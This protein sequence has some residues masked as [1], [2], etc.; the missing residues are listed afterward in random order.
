MFIFGFLSR[1]ALI[2]GLYNAVKIFSLSTPKLKIFLLV[3]LVS[4]ILLL[5]PQ[6][7]LALDGLYWRIYSLTTGQD[8]RMNGLAD[9][10]HCVR[11]DV[12]LLFGNAMC[13]TK[14]ITDFALDNMF[15][16]TFLSSGLFGLAFLLLVIAAMTFSLRKK[17]GTAIIFLAWTVIVFSADESVGKLEILNPVVLWSILK[18]SN[19]SLIG[20]KR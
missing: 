8:N 3:V 13:L 9:R 2:I 15:T 5:L 10:L 20:Q 19:A 11:D 18:Y 16:F 4:M 17:P 1:L 12:D 6:L 14:V 7:D